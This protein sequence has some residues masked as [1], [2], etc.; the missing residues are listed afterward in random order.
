M[1]KNFE[2]RSSAAEL[3]NHNWI[4]NL[5]GE[6]DKDVTEEDKNKLLKNLENFSN[7]NKFQ[8]TI[9][10]ILLNLTSDK[11]EIKMLRTAFMK[12]DKDHDGFLSTKEFADAEKDLEAF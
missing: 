6:H 7:S 9:F 12:I 2:E 5:D 4:K 1:T 11:T 8:K 10:S 3:L